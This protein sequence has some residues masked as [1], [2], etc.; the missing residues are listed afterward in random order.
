[1]QRSLGQRDCSIRRHQSRLQ[2]CKRGPASYLSALQDVIPITFYD[3]ALLIKLWGYACAGLRTAMN[4]NA[5]A[6]RMLRRFPIETYYNQFAY[7][8]ILKHCYML[9]D[10]SAYLSINRMNL[11]CT[12]TSKCFLYW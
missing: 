2:G 11:V 12:C 10:L 7:A 4:C 3:R 9:I 1:M 5:K 6:P 8:R